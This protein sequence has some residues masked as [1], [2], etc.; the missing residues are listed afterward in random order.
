MIL[1]AG[2]QRV[3]DADNDQGPNPS[4]QHDIP[5]EIRKAPRKRSGQVHGSKCPPEGSTFNIVT[6]W[7][8]LLL[9]LLLL[10]YRRPIDF[11]ATSRIGGSALA[12]AMP[13]EG[14]RKNKSS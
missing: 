9:L 5:R 7:C 6:I 11:P 1:V 8:L 4:A 10:S 12:L 13:V 2:L 14:S 3:D